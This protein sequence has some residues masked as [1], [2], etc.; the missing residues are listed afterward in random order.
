[1]KDSKIS[2]KLIFDGSELKSCLESKKEERIRYALCILLSNILV[3]FKTLK[4]EQ[5]TPWV[6]TLN[7]CKNKTKAYNCLNEIIGYFPE[8]CKM[9][10]FLKR[11]DNLILDIE[12]Q[13]LQ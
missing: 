13:N 5:S 2:E 7:T 9:Q 11:F 6:I 3:C 10:K 8:V 1:M 4:G 12:H